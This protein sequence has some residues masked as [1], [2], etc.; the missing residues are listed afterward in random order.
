[1]FTPSASRPR[2]ALVG[3]FAETDSAPFEGAPHIFDDGQLV[4]LEEGP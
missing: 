3:Y 1:M 4:S 2:A